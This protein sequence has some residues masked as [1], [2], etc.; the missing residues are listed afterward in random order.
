MDK[1]ESYWHENLFFTTLG[2]EPLLSVRAAKIRLKIAEIAADE[3]K[4]IYGK[5]KLQMFRW[6]AGYLLQ[7]ITEFFSRKYRA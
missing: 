4:R 1:D 7:V 5:A 3:P 2:I 6:G